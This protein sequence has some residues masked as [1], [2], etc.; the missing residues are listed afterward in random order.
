MRRKSSLRK[1]MMCCRRPGKGTEWT[2][3]LRLKF[4]FVV[5]KITI[6]TPGR[7]QS[8]TPILSRN[9]DNKSIE[10]VLSI[11]IC[12]YT[13]DKWQS[14]TLLPHWRQ[15]AIENTV[16]IGFF[17]HSSIVDSA[18]DCCLPGVISVIGKRLKSLCEGIKKVLGR[19]LKTWFT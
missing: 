8:K 7:R 6:S 1:S 14:K 19:T 12:R 15:M 3:L 2:W 13:G 16:S 18:F 17:S 10:T 11:A 4:F 5:A 9:V